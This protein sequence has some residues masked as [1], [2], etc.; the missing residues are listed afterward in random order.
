MKAVGT[1]RERVLDLVEEGQIEKD[2]VSKR[3]TKLRKDEEY[4]QGQVD[5]LRMQLSKW[6]HLREIS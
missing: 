2:E 1:K 4:L 3:L 6:Q 5:N